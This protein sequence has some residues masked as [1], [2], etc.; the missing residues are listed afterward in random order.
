[1]LG[2]CQPET[3]DGVT[4]GHYSIGGGTACLFYG[5]MIMG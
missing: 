5:I 2:F 1:M 3:T 4:A